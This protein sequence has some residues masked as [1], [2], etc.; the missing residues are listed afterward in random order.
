MFF[1]SI[2]TTLKDLA[3]QSFIN[4]EIVLKTNNSTLTFFAYVQV[5]GLQCIF[6]GKPHRILDCTLD[7]KFCD[8]DVDVW[9]IQFID[10]VR[11][12]TTYF[13][14]FLSLNWKV[15]DEDAL[16]C[17]KKYDLEKGIISHGVVAGSIVLEAI[18][19]SNK[20]WSLNE[21]GLNDNNLV[22]VG[23]GK[24]G[25]DNALLCLK[26]EA[27]ASTYAAHQLLCAK[28]DP[29]WTLHE[30]SIPKELIETITRLFIEG[31]MSIMY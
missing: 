28:N 13:L 29:E 4:D 14:N 16:I 12:I 25:L 2:N 27:I 1:N 24:E 5:E 31:F 11:K 20:L 17:E 19:E 15:S 18:F 23:D 7:R 6:G 10:K 21:I 30:L 22:I 3:L 9:K 8:D 26:K